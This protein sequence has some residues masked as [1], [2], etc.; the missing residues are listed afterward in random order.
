[1]FKYASIPAKW[2]LRGQLPEVTPM[3]SLL[4]KM[5]RFLIDRVPCGAHQHKRD[6]AAAPR[7]NRKQMDKKDSKRSFFCCF[8]VSSNG[9]HGSRGCLAREFNSLVS[10]YVWYETYLAVR[11]WS[12]AGGDSYDQEPAYVL[13]PNENLTP[14][15]ELQKLFFT[16]LNLS[17]QSKTSL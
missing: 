10:A 6:S 1:M 7:V 13:V 9:V 8:S 12:R 17:S 4:K 11:I 16:V 14:T 15:V 5:V 2:R 3:Q